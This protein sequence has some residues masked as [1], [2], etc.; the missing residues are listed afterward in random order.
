MKRHMINLIGLVC[1]IGMV[2]CS[3]MQI[4]DDAQTQAIAYASG[5][6]MGIGINKLAPAVDKDLTRAWMNMMDRNKE[7]D[8]MPAEE[9]LQFYGDMTGVLALH[10]GDP[11]GLIQDLG[12][13]LMLFGAEFDIDGEMVSIEPVPMSVLRFFEMGYENG[14]MI[15]DRERE[16]S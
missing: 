1:V 3:G 12:V 11:Y 15:T 8:M 2:A 5:K 16:L 9:I 13:L 10:I 14:R 7:I 6:A 4:N